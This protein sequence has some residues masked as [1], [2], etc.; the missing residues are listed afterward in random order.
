MVNIKSK[1]IIKK[2]KKK[3]PKFTVNLRTTDFQN[4]KKKAAYT[5]KH[6]TTRLEYIY[7][8]NRSTKTTRIGHT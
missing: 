7:K 4:N 8:T 5:Q 6:F 2:K 3:T 1:L